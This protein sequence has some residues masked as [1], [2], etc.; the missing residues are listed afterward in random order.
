M[1]SRKSNANE[2]FFSRQCG[3]E[4]VE[5]ISVEFQ[6]EFLDLEDKKMKIVFHLDS[7]GISEFHD[8]IMYFIKWKYLEGLI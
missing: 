5:D 3:K 2:D 8:I 1:K 6:D 4:S 7:E